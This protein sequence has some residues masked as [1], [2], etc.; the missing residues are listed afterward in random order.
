AEGAASRAGADRG[1]SKD[2]RAFPVSAPRR[3]PS[4][5]S[6]SSGV[7]TDML[8]VVALPDEAHG[9]ALVAPAV[10]GWALA[11]LVYDRQLAAA[12]EG[13]IVPRARSQIEHAVDG[14]VGG[15]ACGVDAGARRHHDD[16]LRAD[17][18][19]LGDAGDGRCGCAI[20]QIRNPDE[21]GDESR[22]RVLVDV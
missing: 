11:V 12:G 18:E 21:A 5:P 13:D 22:G 1:R 16:L 4:P 8:D 17:R 2:G 20:E 15:Q 14:A 10:G 7:A 9:A 6:A 19:G 3:L